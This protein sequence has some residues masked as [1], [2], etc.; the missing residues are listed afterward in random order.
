MLSNGYLNMVKTSSF[1]GVYS[2]RLMLVFDTLWS[3]GACMYIILYFT[4]A[5][6]A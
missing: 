1:E 4:V 5:S 6:C 2:L 3:V